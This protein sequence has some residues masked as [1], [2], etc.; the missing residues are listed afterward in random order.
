M[1][2]ISYHYQSMD[3]GCQTVKTQNRIEHAEP[4]RPLKSQNRIEQ[5]ESRIKYVDWQ[6]MSSILF[7]YCSNCLPIVWED[8]CFTAV[9]GV[10]IWPLCPGRC[11]LCPR[12]ETGMEWTSIQCGSS[13]WQ[14]RG[15]CGEAVDYWVCWAH[16]YMDCSD[17]CICSSLSH[18]GKAIPVGLGRRF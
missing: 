5:A 12:R 9:W 10:W 16:A 2:S 3:V 4:M 14:A 17:Y 18:V 15:N 11:E 8:N 13:K 7:V 6:A 1:P